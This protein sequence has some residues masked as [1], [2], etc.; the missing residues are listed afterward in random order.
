MPAKADPPLS[1]DELAEK[2]NL[3]RGTIIFHINKLTSTGIVKTENRRYM[4][5][6]DNLKDLIEE[7]ESDITETVD[8]LKNVA[9]KIDERIR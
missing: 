6:V 2:L 8:N 1:S 5:R 4:L 7:L 3:S 9:R